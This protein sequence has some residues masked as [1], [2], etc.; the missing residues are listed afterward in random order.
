[1]FRRL[2]DTCWRQLAAT[3]DFTQKY[4]A[5]WSPGEL[6]TL[7]SSSD[8]LSGF[9]KTLLFLKQFANL[10]TLF[11]LVTPRRLIGRHHHFD[12][13]YCLHLQGWR[14]RLYASPNRC[15]LPR[16]AHDGTSKKTNIAILTAVRTSN[17][18]PAHCS[19]E[20][21]PWRTVVFEKLTVVQL[22]T[23]KNCHSMKSGS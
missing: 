14:Y 3:L 20:G 1:V 11:W 8:S 6:R 22:V 19:T 23:K 4:L 17:L 9:S 10:A 12:T 5:L 13:S 2:T 7:I 15:Y 16:T 18:A 21:K